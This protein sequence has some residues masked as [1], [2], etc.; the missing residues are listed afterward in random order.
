MRILLLSPIA[1]FILSVWVSKRFPTSVMFILLCSTYKVTS[2]SPNNR[3]V[4][5]TKTVNSAE[6]NKYQV[7][8]NLPHEVRAYCVNVTSWYVSI[9]TSAVVK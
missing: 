4:F 2:K 9:G 3:N 7:K 1:L 5:T 8:R 6:P